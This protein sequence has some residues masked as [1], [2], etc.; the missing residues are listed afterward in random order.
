MTIRILLVDDHTILRDGLRALLDSQSD[1]EVVG[2]AGNGLEA[3]NL[4]EE[5]APDIVVMD[6]A[7]PRM[8]GLEATRRIKKLDNP[9]RVLILTQYEHREYVLL[10][11]KA[12]ADGYILKR[13]SGQDLAD[14]IRSVHAGESVLD[15][16]V[17]RTVIEAYVGSSRQPAIGEDVQ[18][19]TDREREV[20][21]LIA[22]G[23]SNQQVARTLHISPKTVDAH[24]MN[25]MNKLDLHNRTALI[26]YAIRKGLV[27][28]DIDS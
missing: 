9:C 26:K 10:L 18:T 27:H 22:E 15:P 24:R 6:V 25:I 28:V 14:A 21:I 8:N 12:G 13:S 3:V 23:Y 2:E 16:T 20:L 17:A 4:V 7:M 5:R 1:M 19:L 11:L